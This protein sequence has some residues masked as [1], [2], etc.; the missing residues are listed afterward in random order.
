MP[1]H[2]IP[3]SLP[4][5][6]GT[7][8]RQQ[9]RQKLTVAAAALI[10]EKGVSGLRIQELAE[11]ADVA[12]G[13]F[14]NHFESKEELV[15]AVVTE[16]IDVRAQTIVAEMTALS[17]PAEI[18]A[19]AT[20][21]VIRIAY[22]D[23]ELAWLFVHLDRADA[24]FEGM[25]LQAALR[26]LDAGIAASRFDVP[27][28]HLALTTMVGGALAVMRGILDGRYGADADSAFAEGQLR[29]LGVSRRDARRIA[30]RVLLSDADS[31]REPLVAG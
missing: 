31:A 14:Y 22:D 27:D 9:T 8:R 24:L 4:P 10:A 6:R 18:V 13:S 25:V 30:N 11:R 20:R 1:R 5:T 23:P 21:R 2:D 19:F 15:E 29:A 26:A 7:Q 3:A 17:D 28:A 12:L 16:T